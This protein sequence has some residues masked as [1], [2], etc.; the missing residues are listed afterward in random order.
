MIIFVLI[1]LIKKILHFISHKILRVFL[2]TLG[3]TVLHFVLYYSGFFFTPGCVFPIYFLLIPLSYFGN[4]GIPF[5]IWQCPFLYFFI[6]HII[7]YCIF[8]NRFLIIL[9]F[10]YSLFCFFN[11]P[12]VDYYWNKNINLTFESYIYNNKYIFPEHMFFI[13][14]PADIQYLVDLA[15][16]ESKEI[17]AGVGWYKRHKEKLIEKN[18]IIIIDSSGLYNIFDKKHYL[19]F[20]ETGTP[21][22]YLSDNHNRT[23][24]IF[25]CS[26]FF[27]GTIQKIDKNKNIIIASTLWTDYF[28]T[29]LYK[30]IMQRI[31]DMMIL[32]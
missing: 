28:V 2:A 4:Y 16:K 1:I 32:E 10:F 3:N 31:Y 9:Y 11:I 20:C 12:K 6:Y 23:N 25:I 26:E 29:S 21:F 18:G 7:I 27:L 13:N 22:F 5:F 8:Q 24:N 15:K 17:I 14:E 19:R 30:I